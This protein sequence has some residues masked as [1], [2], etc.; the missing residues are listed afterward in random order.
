V[1]ELER[2]SFKLKIKATSI[3]GN[4][5]KFDG[6]AAVF[7]KLDFNNDIILTGA[8]KRSLDLQGDKR[9]LYFE[10]IPHDLL[11]AGFVGEDENGLKINGEINLDTQLGREQF[12]N[13]QKGY[14]ET[15]SIGYMTVQADWIGSTRYLKEVALW[16]VTL[17]TLPAM[18]DARVEAKSVVPY[19]DLAIAPDDTVWDTST[20]ISRVAEWAGGAD[21]EKMDWSKYKKS[22]LWF[23][24]DNPTKLLSYKLAIA[25]VIDGTLKVIPKA[26]YEAT[27]I[28]TDAD[29]PDD[30]K[31]KIREQLKRY[32]K[33]MG[34]EMP[35]LE[36]KIVDETENYIRVRV[37][38]PDK[39]VD[40]SFKTITISKDQG[41][42]ALVGKYKSD[43]DG[44]THI[45]NYMFAKDKDW[46]VAKAK[47]WV[48]D[49]KSI[50]VMELKA[51]RTISQATATQI[52]SS[53]DVLKGL[54]N[55]FTEVTATQVSKAI[56]T[57]EALLSET[58]AKSLLKTKLADKETDTTLSA[59]IED[60]KKFT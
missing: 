56:D 35:N 25:D 58:G 2:K 53:I 27:M 34:K 19:Q 47:K 59:L 60:I 36:E 31:D 11:G 45:Q 41:I 10:H 52:Q 16:E 9:P 42:T 55:I 30:D 3:E 49:H 28:L 18:P 40:D 22:F 24:I 50:T 39:F 23:D 20:A 48:A 54:L 44:P 33:K 38:D 32:Y 51:G 13:M 26:I 37:E 43:P 1:K 15:M 8:F 5:G 57:L 17:T 4:I 6:Y 21:K 29:I 14:L 46:T 7:N 12:S